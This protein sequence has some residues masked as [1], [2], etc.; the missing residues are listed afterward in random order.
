MP[1]GEMPVAGDAGI[2][3]PRPRV[4]LLIK[5][6]GLGGAERLLVDVVAARDRERF[7]YE[8]AYVLA[9][10]DA[11]VPAMEATGVP[12]HDL[13]GSASA[14]LRWTAALR[15]LLVRG[16]FDVLHSHLPYTAA[17]GRLVALTLPRRSRPVLVYTEHSLWNKAAVVTKAFNRATVGVDQA[18]VVVSVAARDALPVTLRSRARVVVHGVDRTRFTPLLKQRTAL[19][20]VVRDELGVAD[21]EVLALTVANLRSEK[22]Y[23]VL[24]EAARL[25]VAAGAPVRFFSVGRGPL[26]ADL[27]R[28]A[29]AGGLAGHLRF[30]GARTDTP[31]LMAGADLFVLPSHQEGLPVALMEAMSAGLPVVATTVGGVPDVITDGVE[32]LLV[33]P[34]RAELLAEAVQRLARDPAL[35]TRLADA[36]SQRSALFDVRGAARAIESLYGELLHARGHR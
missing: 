29:D 1:P 17:L 7:D 15:R 21:D 30:L 33:P 19:R 34:G 28:A 32:G 5:G 36:S 25:T 26:L 9:A 14:D 22:G 35:R 18:L 23:D 3:V 16:R 20:R 11:L 10:Q 4:L 13:G 8:V 31:R 24:L 27:E 2:A 12:V 6:L